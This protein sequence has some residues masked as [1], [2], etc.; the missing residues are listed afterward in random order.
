MSEEGKSFTVGNILEEAREGEL[1]WKRVRGHI[2]PY[3]PDIGIGQYFSDLLMARIH[4]QKPTNITVNGPP[5]ISKTYTS[6]SIAQYI[7]PKFDEDQI[8]FS[9]EE[10][11]TQT[12]N[13]PEERPLVM[14]EPEFPMGHRTWANEQQKA[15]IATTRSSRFRVHPLI[16][17]SIS[18]ALLDIVVRKYLLQYMIWLE[19]RGFGT[20]FKIIPSKFDESVYHQP[21]FNLYI[22]MLNARKCNTAWCLGCEKFDTCDLLRA[23]YERKRKRIMMGRY[24][25]D[26]EKTKKGESQQFTYKHLEEILLEHKDK[27]VRNKRG[28][29]DPTSLI[30]ILED[31]DMVLGVGRSKEIASRLSLKYKTPL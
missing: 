1:G 12:I 4:K 19:D 28:N 24:K 6:I 25:Q 20:V 9:Y 5:G 14:D 13:L 29:I 10:Y 22:E 3:S 11:L 21:M 30:L 18:K 27:W 26:L 7:D 31:M 23:R 16:L 2:V 8:V 17:P 15:L